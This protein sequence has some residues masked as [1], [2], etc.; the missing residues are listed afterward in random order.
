MVEVGSLID[1]KIPCGLA[2]VLNSYLLE[3]FLLP[4]ANIQSSPVKHAINTE[5]D[6]EP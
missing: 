3:Y 2:T 6:N 1:I 4:G 5:R